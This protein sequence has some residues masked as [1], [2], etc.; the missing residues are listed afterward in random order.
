MNSSMSNLGE[1]P[2]VLTVMEAARILRLKRS[3]AYELIRQGVIPSFRVGRHIRVPRHEL[4]KMI[5]GKNAGR[6]K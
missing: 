3:T 1:L 4:E 2:P 6:S 5:A